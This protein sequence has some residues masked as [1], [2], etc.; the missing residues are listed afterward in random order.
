[1]AHWK[2]QHM[3]NEN[4]LNR[5]ARV[6]SL[7]ETWR[8]YARMVPVHITPLGVVQRK[9]LIQAFGRDD[10]GNYWTFGTGR[11]E[12]LP[13]AKIQRAIASISTKNLDFENPQ[14]GVERD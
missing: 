4:N 5:A 6:L 8:E 9:H 13:Q 10:G 11:P 2:R 14:E 1:M 7:G 3:T 12:L